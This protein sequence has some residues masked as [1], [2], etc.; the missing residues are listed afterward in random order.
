MSLLLSHVHLGIPPRTP[1]ANW[2]EPSNPESHFFPQIVSPLN[3]PLFMFSVIPHFPIVL[4]YTFCRE[5]FVL[6]PHTVPI[7]SM[8]FFSY[9]LAPSFSLLAGEVRHPV[10]SLWRGPPLC[11]PSISTFVSLKHSLAP[12]GFQLKA[13]SSFPLLSGKTNIQLEKSLVLLHLVPTRLSRWIS[14]VPLR[15]LWNQSIH[16]APKASLVLRLVSL[17]NLLNPD[18]LEQKWPEN[19]VHDSQL[20]NV[21]GMN[22]SMCM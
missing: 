14:A 13:P 19:L 18:N 5:L 22:E 6:F 11:S 4:G 2:G 16:F 9:S 17:P 1:S 12:A 21:R 15:L 8:G 20:I 3:P 7:S 10:R